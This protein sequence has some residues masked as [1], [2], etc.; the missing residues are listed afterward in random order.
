MIVSL[1][2]E[3]DGFLTV[4]LG[5]SREVK[6]KGAPSLIVDETPRWVQPG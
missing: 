4:F 3:Y 6:I 5:H 2:R 1:G